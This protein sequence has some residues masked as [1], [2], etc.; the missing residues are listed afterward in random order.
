MHRQKI[1]AESLL[2]MDEVAEAFE[3]DE[4]KELQE[5]KD[6][7]NSNKGQKVDFAKRWRQLANYEFQLLKSE[8][9][10]FEFSNFN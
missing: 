1:D 9:A 3:P 7:A 2:A 10:C 6:K 5:A 4:L 8:I